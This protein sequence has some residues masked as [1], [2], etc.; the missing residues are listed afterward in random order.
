MMKRCAWAGSDPLY[1]DYHDREWGVPEHRDRRLFEMLILEG[2]QAG[3]SWL[4]I[5]RKRPGYRKAFS[6]FDPRKVARFDQRK[7]TRL[8]QDPVS[9]RSRHMIQAAIANARAVLVIQREF[10]SFDRFIWQFVAGLP[11]VNRRRSLKAI[12]ASTEQSGAMSRELK[13]RGLNFV[14][15]TICYAFMQATGMVNDHV[16]SCFRWRQLLSELDP[17]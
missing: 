5:L 13:R 17:S 1:V 3:L 2:A 16:T 6:G 10:G 8:L 14:G 7:V 12:P 4:T 9:E 11:L 15:P